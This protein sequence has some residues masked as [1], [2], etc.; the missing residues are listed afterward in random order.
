[1]MDLE[2]KFTI[3]DVSAMF[4]VNPETVRRWC[5]EEKIRYIKLPG[6]KSKYRFSQEGINEF[7]SKLEPKPTRKFILDKK[8]QKNNG[9]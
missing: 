8:E 1:M 5:R 2:F 6:R 9:E 4:A 3:E 7:V